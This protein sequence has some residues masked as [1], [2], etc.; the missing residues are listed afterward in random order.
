MPPRSHTRLTDSIGRTPLVGR[1]GQL[2]TLASYA[3]T[4]GAGQHVIAFLAGVSGVGKTRLLEQFPPPEHADEFTVLRG[5]A[6]QAEGMPPYLP[7]LEALGDYFLTAHADQSRIDVGAHLR[8]T[9]WQHN[10]IG[11]EIRLHRQG[12]MSKVGHEAY[13]QQHQPADDQWR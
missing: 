10:R 12:D 5:G 4:G 7:F 8:A 13:P 9:P 1:S 11:S 2:T 6:S 3:A